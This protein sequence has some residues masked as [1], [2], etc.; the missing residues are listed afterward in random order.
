MV[1]WCVAAHEQP[2]PQKEERRG[3]RLD[4]LLH[5]IRS[6]LEVRIDVCRDLASDRLTLLEA[7]ACF[8]LLDAQIP[9]AEYGFLVVYPGKSEGERF[10][11]K[12]I[13]FMHMLFDCKNADETAALE[14]L[15]GRLNAELQK[16]LD[17]SGTIVLPEM[18]PRPIAQD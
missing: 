12:V 8:R 14:A 15:R 2:D 17:S 18:E 11:R 16:L 10:C 7:A 3:E 9:A 4:K 13:A 1:D 6:R 5:G